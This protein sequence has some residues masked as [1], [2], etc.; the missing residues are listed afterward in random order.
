MRRTELIRVATVILLAVVIT[1][2][3]A[4]PLGAAAPPNGAL[5]SASALELVR[6]TVANEVAAANDSSM[7]HMFRS[8]KQSPQGSQTRLYVETREAMAGMTIAYNDKPLSPEQMKG[9]DDRLAGLAGNPEQ[10]KRNAR[11][12]WRQPTAPCAS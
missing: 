5:D 10:L 1:G 12:N 9:E 4:A 2:S 8:H 3:N 11:K 6:A 7:K